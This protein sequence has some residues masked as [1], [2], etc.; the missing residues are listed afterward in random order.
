MSRNSSQ[1]PEMYYFGCWRGVGHYLHAS[2][3][4][5]LSLV[6]AWR[7][8]RDFPCRPAA[9]DSSFLPPRLPQVEGR[10]TL[11]HL[12]GWTVLSFWDRSGDAR[13][14]SHSTFIVRGTHP[15]DVFCAMAQR[16][17][18]QVWARMPFLVVEWVADTEG[19]TYA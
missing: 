14:G 9:L 5:R 10:A 3:G 8:P 19:A 1:L 11:V 2:T 17:F 13:P 4:E 12:N 16:T 7:L 15:F 18:P 6:D